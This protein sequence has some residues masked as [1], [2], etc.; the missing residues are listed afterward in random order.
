M[1]S[2]NGIVLKTY[3]ENPVPKAYNSNN[4][5]IELLDGI[6]ISS[7]QF[8]IKASM[9]DGVTFFTDTLSLSVTCPAT[10]DFDTFE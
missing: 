5:E 7:Y 4:F 1:N 2:P 9:R 10:V 6:T 3:I 8:V